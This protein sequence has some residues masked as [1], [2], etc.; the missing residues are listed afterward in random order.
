MVYLLTPDGEYRHLP[1]PGQVTIGRDASNDIVIKDRSVS[2]NHCRLTLEPIPN[3]NKTQ[4]WLEDLGTKNG[5]YCGR[6]TLEIEKVVGRKSVQVGFVFRV[7]YVSTFCQI[8]D[9]LPRQDL[10]L[11][12]LT[13][14]PNRG[15][16]VGGNPAGPA[17]VTGNLILPQQTQPR[18]IEVAQPTAE[19]D[20]GRSVQFAAHS[21]N[22]VGG[23]PA[24]PTIPAKKAALVSSHTG[25][26]PMVNLSAI[27][28]PSGPLSAVGAVLQSMRLPV[29]VKYDAVAKGSLL[30]Y[31]DQ[32]DQWRAGLLAMRTAVM[33]DSHL[34]EYIKAVLGK[35]PGPKQKSNRCQ[36][37][38]LQLANPKPAAAATAPS[39]E[40]KAGNTP[41]DALLS[42]LVAESMLQGEEG[43][44]FDCNEVALYHLHD[45]LQ[46]C[47]LGAQIVPRLSQGDGPG[48]SREMDF[49]V[50]NEL[51]G[52]L[53]AALSQVHALQASPVVAA[54]HTFNLSKGN[55]CD[56]QGMLAGALLAMQKVMQFISQHEQIV[57][58]SFS[59]ADY[60]QVLL[61]SISMVIEDLYDCYTVLLTLSSEADQAVITHTHTHK[62]SG[63]GR[64]AADMDLVT[65]YNEDVDE[66]RS[67]K[68]D[69]DL[70]SLLERVRE[71]E[72]GILSEK[73][74]R[75]SRLLGIF[76]RFQLRC[77]FEHLANRA[78]NNK[79]KGMR[80][81]DFSEKLAGKAKRK[82]WTIWRAA[83]QRRRNLAKCLS[84][85]GRV[86][87]S[88]LE[89]VRRIYWELWKRNAHMSP[90]WARATDSLA[91]LKLTVL[92]LQAQLQD[93]ADK[94]ANIA[95]LAA[96]RA[97]NKELSAG[98]NELRASVQNLQ[99]QLLELCNVSLAKRRDLVLHDLLDKEEAVARS[100][101]EVKFLRAEL[102][103]LRAI[104]DK[105]QSR[106]A[107]AR[108]QQEDGDDLPHPPTDR[109]PGHVTD[110]QWR[111]TNGQAR[112]DNQVPP[113]RS[114]G[115][116]VKERRQLPP[117]QKAGMMSRREAAQ[118]VLLEVRRLRESMARLHMQRDD[119][120]V[121]TADETQKRVDQV[122]ASQQMTYR[123]LDM[124]RS[125]GALRE[126]LKQRVG[127]NTYA[128]LVMALESMGVG[129]HVL[130]Q[131]A[132]HA[133]PDPGAVAKL[134]K[135]SSKKL[136]GNGKEYENA[137][138]EAFR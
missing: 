27:M 75:L 18:A 72:A 73:F 3:T 125:A 101:K 130:Q 103:N 20:M 83:Y 127:L 87:S 94:D 76:A 106:Q 50:Q 121:V 90:R 91:Q 78:K 109:R 33:I 119:L 84:R 89:K 10:N 43:G 81:F 15:A 128:D 1:C 60:Y 37:R 70:L 97:M 49:L 136:K 36:S 61:I 85:M 44:C 26:V 59:I 24:A 129:A 138:D 111:M 35:V 63:K 64:Y 14:I 51:L 102:D 12:E 105:D 93:Q 48:S 74:K 39:T 56:L 133:I 54:M 114:T 112:Y 120:R 46:H 40:E 57:A 92:Q 42:E 66:L 107:S 16:S 69:A 55:T 115:T 137:V 6:D 23:S 41:R 122:M 8:L 28:Q 25:M 45:L 11:P 95:A 5:T 71:Q 32:L 100:R 67:L 113:P 124:E 52:V 131:S 126:L 38:Y 68:Y 118:I 4:I 58:G 132:L 104:V 47:L 123:L 65:S 9:N 110:Q 21:D 117:I 79:R 80:R 108:Q 99:L 31:L 19:D 88:N 53:Q 29:F 134:T 17:V 135:P 7:G 62:S 13:I 30:K 82:H 2:T 116:P 22:Q 34:D 98:N 96:E 77:I 86:V